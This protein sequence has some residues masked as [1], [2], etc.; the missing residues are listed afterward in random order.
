[1]FDE[2]GYS[3]CSLD[4]KGVLK[5]DSSKIPSPISDCC[6]KGTTY[7]GLSESTLYNW[8]HDVFKLFLL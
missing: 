5:F 8:L 2:E 4:N 6:M 7:S 1:M 3:A